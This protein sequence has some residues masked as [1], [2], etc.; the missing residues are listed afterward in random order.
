[1]AYIYFDWSMWKSKSIYLHVVSVPH[2]NPSDKDCVRCVTSVLMDPCVRLENVPIAI[3]GPFGGQSFKPFTLNPD[4]GVTIFFCGGAGIT[5]AI[6]AI[7]NCPPL[8]LSNRH[9][10]YVLAWSVRNAS[11]QSMLASSLLQELPPG[12]KVIVYETNKKA[13]EGAG[14]NVAGFKLSLGTHRR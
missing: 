6:G 7:Q 14:N 10:L 13:L 9:G 12:V 4:R 1:M 5:P 11:G 2:P 8:T 3:E